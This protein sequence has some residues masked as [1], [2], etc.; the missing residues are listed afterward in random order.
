MKIWITRDWLGG[1]PSYRCQIWTFVPARTEKTLSDGRFVT[2]WVWPNEASDDAG[3]FGVIPFYVAEVM[4]R[5]TDQDG[6][7]AP[8][9]FEVTQVPS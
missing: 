7:D 9:V 1:W 3:V 2:R 5:M 8:L 6:F 4:F